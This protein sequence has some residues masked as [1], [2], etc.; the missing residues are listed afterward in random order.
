MLTC[1]GHQCLETDARLRTRGRMTRVGGKQNSQLV[2]LAA[3]ALTMSL[4][5]GSLVA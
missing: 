1:N 2:A 3:I 5:K 4:P